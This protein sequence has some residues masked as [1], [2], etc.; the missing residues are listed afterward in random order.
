MDIFHSFVVKLGSPL[1]GR[2]LYLSMMLLQVNSAALLPCSDGGSW[3]DN[4]S[5]M[6]PSVCRERSRVF[7]TSARLR[8]ME[9][10]SKAH[11]SI[12]S[13]RPGRGTSRQT[14]WRRLLPLPRHWL[15]LFAR[16]G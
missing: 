9:S 4:P 10:R 15:F 7:H 8:A 14:P 1:R 5:G 3:S 6:E 13:H 11:K 12:A 2:T 16:P